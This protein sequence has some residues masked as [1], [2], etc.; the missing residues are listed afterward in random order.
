MHKEPTA[1]ATRDDLLNRLNEARDDAERIDALN[2]LSYDL[3]LNEIAQ[4]RKY[5]EE[6]RL[7][8]LELNDKPRLARSL[9]NLGNAEELSCEYAQA[10]KHLGEAEQL[11]ISLGNDEL[12]FFCN[13]CTGKVHTMMGDYIRALDYFYRNVHLSEKSGDSRQLV[14]SLINTGIMHMRLEEYPQAIAIYERSM[15]ISEETGNKSGLAFSYV[16]LGIVYT[17]MKEVEKGLG[18][19]LR[20]AELFRETKD[21]VNYSNAIGNIGVAYMELGQTELAE[22]YVTESFELKEAAGDLN[23][24]SNFLSFA[25]LYCMQKRY[26]EALENLQRALAVAESTGSRHMFRQVYKSFCDYYEE[27]ADTANELKY[28]KLYHNTDKEIVSEEKNKQ[29]KNLQ[30]KFEVESIQREKEIYRLK[31][32]DLASANEQ[33]SKQK[34]QIEEKNKDITDSISYAR[35]IQRALLAHE[36]DLRRNLPDY[37]IL[38]LPKDIVSGD[39][40]WAAETGNQFLLAACDCTGHGV[41]GA[42]MSLLNISFLNECVAEKNVPDPA[43]IL[44]HVRSRLIR[45]L[46]DEITGESARDGM[47]ASIACFDFENRTF[48]FACANNPVWI[49]RE[50]TLMEF[51]PDKMPVGQHDGEMRPFTSQHFDLEK[52]DVIYLFTDGYA[53]QFGGPDGKKFKYR[54]MK[55]ALLSLYGKPMPEQRDELEKTFTAWKGSLEQVDDVLVIGVRI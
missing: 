29:M 43:G 20:S 52:G 45:A 10:L 42:F 15:K 24:L 32:I 8:S 12:L 5:A 11:F 33:I 21:K 6:A 2:A 50:G 3:R 47:D 35:R 46:R 17:S 1:Q 13:S 36:G 19:F 4:S 38:Y 25:R 30:V 18:C 44:G 28:F 14:H 23:Q 53:D 37:F 41:P 22:K 55:D 39:F 7:L 34:E 48:S 31:N 51:A 26:P 16:N 9:L 27:T 40:Y 54:Q 49:I